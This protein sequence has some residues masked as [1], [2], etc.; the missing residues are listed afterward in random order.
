MMLRTLGELKT[1]YSSESDDIAKA[2]YGPCFEHATTYDRITGFFSSTVFHLLHGSLG[3][4]IQS[5]GGKMRIL[6]SPRMSSVDA[7]GLVYGYSARNDA[8]LSSALKNELREL[9][10]SPAAEGAKLFAALVAGGRLDIRLAK[11]AA[12]TASNSKSMFHDKVGVFGDPA[13]DSV[14]FRGS[15]NETYLGLSQH[16]NVES[17]DVWPS[18]V[19]GRD[20]ERVQKATERFNDL[21]E[22]NVPGVTVVHLPSEIQNELEIVAQDVD[23]EALLRDTTKPPPGRPEAPAVGGIALRPHQIDAYEAWRANGHRG[24]FAHATGSGKSVSGLYC[25]Q[26]A[27]EAGLTPVILVPSKLLL[28]QWFA[29]VREI[30]GAK[31]IA[32]GAGHNEWRRMPLIR[33]ALEQRDPSKMPYVIL[34]VLNSAATPAFRAQVERHVSDIFALFDES[35][36]AGSTQYRELFDWLQTPQRLGLS[37]TPDRANDPEGTAAV[38]T[39]F[40]GT[41]HRYTLKNALDDKVLAKYVYHPQ[42]VSLTDD[43]QERWD[44]LTAEIRR[45]TASER[46]KDSTAPM[47]DQLKMK[48]IERARIAKSAA[49]KVP[50]AVRT[51]ADN[52]KPAEKQKWLVYCDNQAQVEDLRTGLL[53]RGITAWAY[54]T[55]MAGDPVNTLRMFDA[56]GGIIISIRCLDEGVDIPSATHALVIASSRNEREFIQ[57]RGRILRQAPDKTIATLHDILVLPD[58]VQRSDSSWPLVVGEIARA[59]QFAVW[60]LNT[61]SLSKIEAK[62]IDMGIS[63]DELSELM[64][65]GFEDED[66]D[67]VG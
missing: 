3:T 48:L 14:G 27:I 32:V 34:A 11:V 30:L 52:Y 41:V 8:E 26:K 18:W 6:C 21:W 65:A 15:L 51:V 39:F 64:A 10:Q 53:E 58:A 61:D 7:E 24:I 5:N 57:R 56:E 50:A 66:E 36:R 45:R 35:H 4:F 54:H 17:I 2:F 23:L 19:G 46:S 37:A 28:E 38:T 29:H 55:A 13:G 43:E 67:E 31:V 49:R 62:V 44:L 47:S 1:E 16:G 22:G 12:T 63:L 42:W 20:A 25:A 33:A 9:L 59:S 40:D 60:G